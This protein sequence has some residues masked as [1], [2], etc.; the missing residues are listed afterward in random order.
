MGNQEFK[1]SLADAL[2]NLTMVPEWFDV[3]LVDGA[4]WSL[5]IEVHFY[6]CVYLAIRLSL[7]KRI[8]LLLA[9]WLCVSLV[10]AIHRMYVLE[11]WLNARWGPFF[12]AGAACY[13]IRTRGYTTTRAAL[14]GVA[15][16]LSVHS[17][18]QELKRGSTDLDPAIVVG[19]ISIFYLL[20]VLI[21]FNKWR[22]QEAA[23]TTIPGFLTYPVYL[24]H[25]NIGY[26]VDQKLYE[27]THSWWLS[28]GI[29][30]A[31]VL[32][33]AT[34]IHFSIERKAG[35]KLRSWLLNIRTQPAPEM[36]PT[37]PRQ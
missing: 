33:T 12:V 22:M 15:Y 26:V 19:V 25:Q 18:L 27:L 28:I 8:E 17:V 20:F 11:L 23:W 3:P 4:Y 36:S 13:L 34:L 30:L 21:A 35:P 31:G 24:I 6:I 1:L 32:T 37:N 10:D 5:A 7:L 16:L 2:I 29:V 9:L 14:M